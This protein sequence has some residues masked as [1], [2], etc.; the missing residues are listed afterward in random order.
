MARAPTP[1]LPYEP[2][3]ENDRTGSLS[4]S[5]SGSRDPAVLSPHFRVR[6]TA[7]QGSLSDG[8][9]PALLH[10]GTS[11][12]CRIFGDTRHPGAGGKPVDNLCIPVCCPGEQAPLFHILLKQMTLSQYGFPHPPRLHSLALWKTAEIPLR[13]N[14]DPGIM[15]I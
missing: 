4:T 15:G 9:D 1:G 6:A 7:A 14:I 11:L 3:I 5:P 13:R 8:L 10:R 12:A 2:C